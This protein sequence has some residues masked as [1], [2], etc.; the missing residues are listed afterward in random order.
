G[1]HWVFI[2]A[3]A[4][5]HHIAPRRNA[6]VIKAVMGERVAEVWV[7]DCFGA[8][9][10]APS[11]AF[12]LCLQHQL[13]D[14]QRLLEEQPRNAWAAKLQKLFREAIHLKQRFAEQQLCCTIA[15]HRSLKL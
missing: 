7:C 15:Q 5:Y 11:Q 6:A 2:G 9:L 1:W 14:L 12:Q 10:K 4:V 3:E 13:R 8:Q